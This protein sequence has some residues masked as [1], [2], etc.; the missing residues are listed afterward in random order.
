VFWDR[1]FCDLGDSNMSLSSVRIVE[2]NSSEF[3]ELRLIIDMELNKCSLESLGE[4][5][6]F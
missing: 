2:S 4:W 3:V 6:A 1:M 5:G